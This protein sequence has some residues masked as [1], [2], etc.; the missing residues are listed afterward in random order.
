M[1]S[2]LSLGQTAPF[3]AYFLWR[4]KESKCRPAQG[5][6]K[7]KFITNT[8]RPKAKK[9]PSSAASQPKPQNPMNPENPPSED[10][11]AFATEVFDAARRGDAP[12]L[13]A[14]LAKGLPPN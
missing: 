2:F 12:I 3:F 9:A 7:I 13:E 5:S 4:S 1:L 6:T 8:N 11:I 14:L 10:L